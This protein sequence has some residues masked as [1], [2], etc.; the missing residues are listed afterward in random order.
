MLPIDS[1]RSTPAR[2]GIQ[3][4][5]T[6]LDPKARK[7]LTFVDNRQDAS[8]QAGHFNDFVQVAQLRGA[9]SQ[10]LATAPLGLTHDAVAQ[11]VTAALGLAFADF[12][13]N[14]GAKFSARESAERALRQVVEYRLYTDLKRGWRVTM[15]NLEQ[16]G[17]LLVH[18][19]DLAE[20][21]ADTD[22]W[23]RRHPAL[24]AA[25]SQLREEL[26]CILLDELRRVLAIDVDC[27]TELG[28]ERVERESRQHL[29]EPWSIGDRERP[30]QVGTVFARSGTPG[31]PRTD[32][33]VSGRSAFGRYV[34]SPA[35]LGKGLTTD[36]S[37]AVIG[38]LLAALYEVG[39]LTQVFEDANGVPG[40]R[41][42][43]SGVRWVGGDGTK[44][45]DDPLR[46]RLESEA[47]A[48]VNPF[49]RDLYRD[50]AVSLTGLHAKEH[51]AQVPP[52]QREIRERDFREGVLPLLYCSP[53]MELGVD[54][55][56]L[57][58]VAMRNVPPTPANYAQR[59][60]RAGRSGQPALVAT[61]CATGNAHDSYWFRRSRDMVAGSVQRPRG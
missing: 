2:P 11:Q 38:D 52:D 28:F 49:F 8:L 29:R 45:A 3:V 57:N 61:Y 56:S 44:G 5:E 31:G 19:V 42:K 4:H 33:N 34:R 40:Y 6:Q 50:V 25:P 12:A 20:I 32:L 9:L 21:A 14:P 23:S 26:A 60:G 22:T 30:E 39:T 24:R 54:I 1:P 55:A 35:G 51:T 15:P 17:L 46:R 18:Y 47:V 37:L 59:S 27:L 7:L 48:R 53:T 43:A 16:V 36:D 58:A 13:V 41:L 10:A